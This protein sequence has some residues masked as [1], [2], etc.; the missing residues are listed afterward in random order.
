ML[1]SHFAAGKSS[2][3]NRS[4]VSLAE[5]IKPDVDVSEGERKSGAVYTQPRLVDGRRIG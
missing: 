2:T 4:R 1:N 3:H 5:L